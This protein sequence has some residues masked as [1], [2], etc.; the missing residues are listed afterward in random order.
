M[1]RAAPLLFLSLL[2]ARGGPAMAGETACWFENGAVVAPAAIGGIAGDYVIDLSAPRTLLHLDV[3]QAAGHVETALTLPVRLA[4]QR[5]EA[6]P[7]DVQALDYRAVGFS[8]PIVGVI[9]ADI[10]DHYAV[11]LDFSPC[12]LRLE[13]PGPAQGSRPGLA[14]TMVGGVPTIAAA[15][16]DGLHGVSGPFAL[17]T[18]SGGGVRARGAA[19]GP[20][21][22]PAGTLRGL[23]LHG[24]LRQDLPAVVAGDLP[25][26]VVGALG[27][28]VLAGYRLRLDPQALRLWLIPVPAS[29]ATDKEKGPD[30]TAEP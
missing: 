13:R 7:I 23:S 24:A 9:G 16:S 5:V 8:T 15:A 3:A 30:V 26:G 12:R 11:T 4:G 17:D 2:A 20:R 22:K 28:Q 25:D 29:E 19:D 10:L 27:V 21:Q 1:R 18:A 6:A 14:V